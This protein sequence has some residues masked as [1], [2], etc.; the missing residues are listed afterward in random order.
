MKTSQNLPTVLQ[1]L[2]KE[3]DFFMGTL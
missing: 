3:G 2:H 1:K